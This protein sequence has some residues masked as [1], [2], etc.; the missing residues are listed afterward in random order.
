M[1][2]RKVSDI[3]ESKGATVYSIEKDKGIGEAV[4]VMNVNKLGS[5][6]VVDD[7]GKYIGILT[8]RDLLIHFGTCGDELCNYKVEELMTKEL[9]CIMADDNL[10][11]AMN[12]MSA[13][14]IRHLPVVSEGEI[15]GLISITD[16]INNM[17]SGLEEETKLLKDYITDQYPR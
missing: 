12:V 17:R 7:S 9:I 3:I 2:T 11:Q 10:D 6:M 16:V 14:K 13:N 1:K 8:E 15:T 4:A 5:L